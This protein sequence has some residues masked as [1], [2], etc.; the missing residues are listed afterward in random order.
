VNDITTNPDDRAI[1]Q[2]IT[3]MAHNMKMTFVAEGVETEE[4]LK[5][6]KESQCDEAHGTSSISL[7]L[8]NCLPN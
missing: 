3:A 2:A 1:I 7:C 8:M 6:L 4:Q 5:F